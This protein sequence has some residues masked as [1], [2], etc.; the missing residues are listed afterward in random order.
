MGI[1]IA[2]QQGKDGKSI[3][4]GTVCLDPGCIQMA[5]D[6]RCVSKAE[7]VDPYTLTG[8][9]KVSKEILD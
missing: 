7:L 4:C 5:Q 8:M 3:V 1:S 9:T 6:V 2:N